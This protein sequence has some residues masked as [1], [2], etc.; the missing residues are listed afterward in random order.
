MNNQVY[1]QKNLTHIDPAP[2]SISTSSSQS[3]PKM[4]DENT[5]AE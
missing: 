2:A 1:Q 4:S 3:P 5:V